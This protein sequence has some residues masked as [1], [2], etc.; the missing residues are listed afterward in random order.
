MA[1]HLLITTQIQDK[2][3]ALHTQG[4]FPAMLGRKAAALLGRVPLF[5]ASVQVRICRQ[6]EGEIVS[7]MGGILLVGLFR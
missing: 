2:R 1:Q 3:P 5:T 4:N 7:K 6:Q